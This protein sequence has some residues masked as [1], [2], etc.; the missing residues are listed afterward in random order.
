VVVVVVV[1]IDS[2]NAN[3][4]QQGNANDYDSSSNTNNTTVTKTRP[5]PTPPVTHQKMV[6]YYQDKK[7]QA[8]Q[9]SD[10]DHVYDWAT[11]K[12]SVAITDSKAEISHLKQV[13]WMCQDENENLL[14][15]G[16]ELF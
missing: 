3:A 15:D 6:N 12:L 4:T 13:L 8:S 7:K 14:Q 16:Q 2:A 1:F 5:V 11:H 10:H 9:H